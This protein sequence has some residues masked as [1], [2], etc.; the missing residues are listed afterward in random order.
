MRYEVN[1]AMLSETVSR[2]NKRGWL[3]QDILQIKESSPSSSYIL[4]H[5]PTDNRELLGKSG[6]LL[7]DNTGLDEHGEINGWGCGR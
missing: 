4:E 6:G 7:A 3:N 2:G 1:A 5:R